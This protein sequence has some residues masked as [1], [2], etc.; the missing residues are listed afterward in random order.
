MKKLL[1]ITGFVLVFMLAFSASA[2]YLDDS[3]PGSTLGSDWQWNH[4]TTCDGS[5]NNG[6]ILNPVDGNW[7]QAAV[8]T[9]DPSYSWVTLGG[10]VSYEFTVGSWDISSNTAIGARIYLS[11]TDGVGVDPW[12][13]YNNSN[14]VMGELS[15]NDG[16]FW[17]SL[18]QK[19]DSPSTAYNNDTYKLGFLDAGTD[20]EGTTFGFT[21]SDAGAATIYIDDGSTR[22]ASNGM[23]VATSQFNNDT[24]LYVGVINGTGGTFDENQTVTLSNVKV[25]PEPAV[26]VLLLGGLF[27]LRKRRFTRR[28][29]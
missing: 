27:F 24:R 11:T 20:V 18:Y 15:L 2:Q 26:G 22:T 3:F 28:R 10:S 16:N 14:G 23:S 7:R 13:D 4:M 6:L 21:V 19:T 29:R 5:V 25:I 1:G 12:D 17:W 9:P 8:A